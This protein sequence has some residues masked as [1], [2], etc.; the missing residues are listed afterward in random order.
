MVKFNYLIAV[1][2]IVGEMVAIYPRNAVMQ[3]I[4]FGV[5]CMGAGVVCLANSPKFSRKMGINPDL[6]FERGREGKAVLAECLIL[7]GAALAEVFLYLLHVPYTYTSTVIAVI[8]AVCVSRIWR[9]KCDL[10]KM[11]GMP[12]PISRENLCTLHK[13]YNLFLFI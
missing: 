1:L 11:N 12:P 10:K 4:F 9:G 8:G 6:P 13:K 3:D 5:F 7:A 2:G